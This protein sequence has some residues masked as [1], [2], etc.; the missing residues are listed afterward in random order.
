MFAALTYKTKNQLLIAGIAILAMLIYLFAI[1][2]T[3]RVYTQ[4]SNAKNKIEQASN[5]P[6]MITKLEKELRKIDEKIGSQ[7]YTGINTEQNLLEVITI[8]CQKNHAVLREFPQATASLQGNLLVETNVFIV[9]G[10]FNTLLNLVYLLE[11]KS[12]LGKVASVHY[13]FKKDIKTRDIVLTAT[14]YIQNIKK[15]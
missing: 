10:N 11:Q 12:K 3:I 8:Y 5:I 14:I 6:F 9:E 13:Q 7:N 1:K 4:Y 15:Q 2:K